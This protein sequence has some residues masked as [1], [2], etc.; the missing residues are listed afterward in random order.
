M[1]WAA[2][3]GRA[4]PST[5][6]EGS[7]PPANRLPANAFA[8]QF[9]PPDYLGQFGAPDGHWYPSNDS[10]PENEYSRRPRR[11]TSDQISPELREA[12]KNQ[13]LVGKQMLMPVDMSGRP[14]RRRNTYEVGVV[15]VG[16]AMT[17]ADREYY[18]KLRQG[19]LGYGYGNPYGEFAAAPHVDSS[20]GSSVTKRRTQAANFGSEPRGTVTSKQ[21]PKGVSSTSGHAH[22][23]YKK[24]DTNV[25]SYVGHSVWGG[26]RE[27][28]TVPEATAAARAARN[29]KPPDQGGR[30]R[31]PPFKL[32]DDPRYRPVK[33]VINAKKAVSLMAKLA[34][35]QE[36]A[37]AVEGDLLA[38]AVANQAAGGNRFLAKFAAKAGGGGGAAA[39][40][41]KL[42]AAAAAA[43]PR[44]EALDEHVSTHM[45]A[46]PPPL[47]Q[48]PFGA[49]PPFVPL[50]AWAPPG[51]PPPALPPI[52]PMGMPPVGGHPMFPPPFP[53]PPGALL[54]PPGALAPPLPPPPP[55]GFARDWPLERWQAWHAERG[56]VPP[57]GLWEHY[58]QSV[59]G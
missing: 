27:D 4:R 24:G 40:P 39:A 42:F 43:P 29:G 9:P 14:R 18:M 20:F 44:L 54:P 53:P 11:H 16:G 28:T 32:P 26:S 30:Q 45:P 3:G 23:L 59:S 46:Y 49:P 47:G 12:V 17:R 5:S 34:G 19:L 57:P 25:T 41:A 48:P 22:Q 2:L 10:S 50:A 55:P 7:R 35:V 8:G 6:P 56:I 58:M 52:G 13:A 33:A 15:G 37:G 51:A 21:V 1:G 31:P 38:E 36:R